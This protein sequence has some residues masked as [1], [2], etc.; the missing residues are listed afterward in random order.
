M[1]ITSRYGSAQLRV[2]ANRRTKI[3]IEISKK[4]PGKVTGRAK[5]DIYPEKT[6]NS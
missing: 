1:T 3:P 4:V 5:A 6:W 2:T